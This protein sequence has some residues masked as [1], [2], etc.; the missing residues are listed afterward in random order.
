MP[1]LRVRGVFLKH[2]T[3]IYISPHAERDLHV[4]PMRSTF[5]VR[6]SRLP[7]QF[8][9]T[10]L[11]DSTFA[12]KVNFSFFYRNKL[13]ARSHPFAEISTIQS[14]PV[15]QKKNSSNSRAWYICESLSSFFLHHGDFGGQPEEIGVHEHGKPSSS[16]L[17]R[18]SDPG[19]FDP[20]STESSELA[21]SIYFINSIQRFHSNKCKRKYS[22][23]IF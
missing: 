1:S 23:N 9:F 13:S 20:G 3:E 8:W 18:V 10:L 16:E 7:R 6:R 12:W 5:L 2:S 15:T 22:V 21:S 4:G 11:L 17:V 14:I 19:Y